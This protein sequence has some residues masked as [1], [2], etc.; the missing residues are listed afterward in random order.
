VGF[1]IQ[2]A[3]VP[4]QIGFAGSALHIKV[5]STHHLG[6]APKAKSHPSRL[7]RPFYLEHQ[8]KSIYDRNARSSERF[9]R[10]EI[11][12]LKTALHRMVQPDSKGSYWLRLDARVGE[13]LPLIADRLL[14]LIEHHYPTKSNP[15]CGNCCGCHELHPSYRHSDYHD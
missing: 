15:P 8:M 4:R 12:E 5:R 2:E 1:C 14:D 9:S 10:Q 7:V 6:F 11:A 13:K 3:R